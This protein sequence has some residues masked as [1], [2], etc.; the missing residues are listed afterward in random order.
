VLATNSINSHFEKPFVILISSSVRAWNSNA[1][2]EQRKRINPT[3]RNAG[4]RGDIGTIRLRQ[5]A[6]VEGYTFT[7]TTAPA[8]KD[9]RKAY[10]KAF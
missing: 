1:A 10:E 9:A 8:P 4:A 7:V 5:L 2:E 3:K 6:N